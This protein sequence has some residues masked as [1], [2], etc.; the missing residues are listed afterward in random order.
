MAQQ[1]SQDNH[2][3]PQYSSLQFYHPAHL[4]EQ[5][6]DHR[7]PQGLHRAEQVPALSIDSNNGHTSYVL[8]R[9]HTHQD[10]QPPAGIV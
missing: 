7:I 8:H 10:S 4:N 1:I 2:I 5:E 3:Q 6:P 9:H